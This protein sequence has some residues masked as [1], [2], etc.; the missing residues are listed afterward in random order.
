[1]GVWFGYGFE[2]LQAW[3][4]ILA[5]ATPRRIGL[6]QPN[7]PV[8][9][10]IPAPAPGYSRQSPWE[11]E[12]SKRLVHAGAEILFWPEA[13]FKGYFYQRSV[14]EAYRQQIAALGVPLVFHDLEPEGRGARRRDYN[15]AV[16]LDSEGD[17][18][19]TYRKIK[20]MPFGE[21]LPAFLTTPLLRDFLGDFLREISP[22][23]SHAT[24]SLAGMRVVPKICYESNDPVLMASGVGADGRGKILAV[25]SQDGWFGPSLQP[26]QHLYS[27]VLRAVENRVPLIH[28][29]N[30]G[31]SG[32]VLPN[33]RLLYQSP[34]FAAVE[35]VVDLPY[36]P[37]RGGSFYSRHPQWVAWGSLL[38]LGL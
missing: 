36:D 14:R 2:R 4:A 13:R 18:A 19:G 1:L 33:G 6:V 27:S 37:Q 38:L 25:L 17:Q 26:F 5:E 30:N 12:A 7:E 32:V 20:P 24:F 15:T 22:G 28:V 31:P 9:V 34:A 35:V 3:E 10:E 11:M 23:T 29:I 8:S 21:F 16:A